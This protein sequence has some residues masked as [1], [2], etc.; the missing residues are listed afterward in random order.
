[1]DKLLL[2]RFTRPNPSSYVVLRERFEAAR[3]YWGSHRFAA[4]T[5]PAFA[6]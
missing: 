1:M 3:E 6:M 5:H 4:V 2:Q